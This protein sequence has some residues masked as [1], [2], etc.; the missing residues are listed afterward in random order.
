[1]FGR[2][3]TVRIKSAEDALAAGR[4]DEAFEIAIAENLSKHDRVPQLRQ[5]IATALFLRGQDRLLARQFTESLADF[6]RAGRCGYAIE[7]IREW[8]LRAEEARDADRG[9]AARRETALNEARR[10]AEA[11]SIVGA[12]EA[13]AG[14]P[15]NDPQ[16]EAMADALDR[17]GRRASEA[18]AAARAALEKNDLH[19]AAVQIRMA[20]QL[21]RSLD[22]LTA[23]ESEL[24]D[25]AV[26]RATANFEAGR[27]DRARQDL[28]ELTDIEGRQ[29]QRI[30]IEELVRDACDAARA[31]AA[32]DHARAAT[33]LGR[34]AR[35]HSRAEWAAEARKHLD[36]IEA[37]SEAIHEGPLGALAPARAA[38]S[39]PGVNHKTPASGE[40][41]PAPELKRPPVARTTEPVEPHQ[42]TP[43]LPRRIMFRIDGVGSFLLVRGD[44]ISVGRAGPGATADI[45]L[46]SDLS[47][48]QAD[49]VRAGEDYFVV[50]Q[51][52]VG[53]GG[54]HVDHALL[55]NGDRIRLGKRVRLKFHRP[56]L[57]SSAAILDLGEG[58]RMETDCRRV[59]L[60][61]GPV[62]IGQTRE[63]H[64]A[65]LNGRGDFVLMERGGRMYVKRVGPSSDATPVEFGVATAVGDLRFTATP[66]ASSTAGRVIG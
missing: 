29:P 23:A 37:A 13:L 3:A 6:E 22:G 57:K 61:S 63:C 39:W 18:L 7:K 32:H 48:K 21:H 26:A 5:A 19:S 8:R 1:M 45:Q 17:Q 31:F 11:G 10:R 42:A 54:A 58:V 36:A 38:N 49:I 16:R 20:K 50:S 27:V 33:L 12:N 14:A 41:L 47:E 15:A 28:D 2:L 44:R 51:S 53:L 65:A 34:I 56:S 24:V 60:W 46:V 52:G 9:A 43:G 64:V 4:L 62:L 40:T 59:I 66:I 30:E 25:Q 35:R 55:Q